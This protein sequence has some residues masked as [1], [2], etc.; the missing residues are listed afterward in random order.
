M[1]HTVDSYKKKKLAE[2]S[3]PHF[4][5]IFFNFIINVETENMVPEF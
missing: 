2:T 4:S 5:N 1:K 3:S